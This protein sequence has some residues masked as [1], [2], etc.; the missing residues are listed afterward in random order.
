MGFQ[1]QFNSIFYIL[2]ILYLFITVSCFNNNESLLI[3]NNSNEY[4]YIYSNSSIRITMEMYT[5]IG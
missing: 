5:S 4:P 2:I 1:S 3:D